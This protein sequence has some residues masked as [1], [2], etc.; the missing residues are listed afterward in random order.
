MKD[1]QTHL[2]ALRNEAAEAA[3]ISQLATVPQKREFSRNS[4]DI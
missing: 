4:Q 2:E 3:L 1:Y